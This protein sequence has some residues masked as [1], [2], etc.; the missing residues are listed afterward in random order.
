MKNGSC[1]FWKR[2]DLWISAFNQF[3]FSLDASGNDR[4]DTSGE[5]TASVLSSNPFSSYERGSSHSHHNLCHHLACRAVLDCNHI[6]T[7]IWMTIS[8]SLHHNV[9]LH[10]TY[11][12]PLLR[13]S[14]GL[15]RQK[16]HYCQQYHHTNDDHTNMSHLSHAAV[17]VC[18]KNHYCQF[19][20]QN[21]IIKIIKIPNKYESPLPRGSLGLPGNPRNV[22][23]RCNGSVHQGNLTIGRK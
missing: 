18:N 14:L 9:N 6:N 21:I 23:R 10:H 20:H 4:I 16:N 13:G 3:W 1:T 7:S 2:R 19:C 22:S 5:E 17:L 11:Y 8:Q 15:P 12:S